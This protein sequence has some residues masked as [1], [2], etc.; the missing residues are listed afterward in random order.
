MFIK[1]IFKVETKPFNPAVE[2]GTQL[3][4]DVRVNPTITT[5]Q[6][7]RRHDVLM[8]AKKQ[9]T[10][11]GVSPDK[12]QSHMYAAANAWF[13]D[14]RRLSEWGFELPAAPQAD[15]YTQHRNIGKR[16]IQFSSIDFTGVLRVTEPARFLEKLGHGFGKAKAFG[17]GLMLLRR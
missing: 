15:R 7:G 2:I 14:P 4:F 10:Q 9:A 17:C 6:T 8:H 16:N 5:K 13:T 11:D 1:I 12:I 3:K